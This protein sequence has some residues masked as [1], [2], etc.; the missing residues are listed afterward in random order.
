MIMTAWDPS[1]MQTMGL[2][3]C[4]HTWQFNYLD[5]HFIFTTFLKFFFGII[6]LFFPL[7]FII[8]C[9]VIDFSEKN[10]YIFFP[11]FISLSIILFSLLVLLIIKLGE[12][13]EISGLLIYSWERKNIFKIADFIVK[14]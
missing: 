9:S 11:C 10:N 1:N 3:P 14:G 6:A 13:C 8:I 12:S 5:N 4:L 2:P 7:L